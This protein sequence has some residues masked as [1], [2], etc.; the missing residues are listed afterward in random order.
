MGAACLRCAVVCSRRRRYVQWAVADGVGVL[1]VMWRADASSMA[2][3][4]EQPSAHSDY[5]RSVAFSPDGTRIV[6]GAGSVFSGDLKVWGG[7]RLLAL[8]DA[9]CS[10]W[11]G[12]C[13]G[14]WLTVWACCA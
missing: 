12:M 9:V 1:C 2:L 8:R 5:V 11:R 6:S 7:R 4:A 14:Q 3:V 13:S 10:W